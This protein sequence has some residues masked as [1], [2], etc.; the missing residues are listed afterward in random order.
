MLISAFL[1][2]DIY[3]LHNFLSQTLYGLWDYYYNNSRGHTCEVLLLCR[4]SY[5]TVEM[6]PTVRTVLYA[7]CVTAILLQVNEGGVIKTMEGR[8]SGLRLNIS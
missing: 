3:G 6:A 2:Y 8:Y 5:M 7:A 1:G 4:T